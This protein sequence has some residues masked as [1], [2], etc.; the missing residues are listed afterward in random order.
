MRRREIVTGHGKRPR[1]RRFTKPFTDLSR[2]ADGV[3]QHWAI[4]N[5]Q[6]WVLD[7]QFGEDANRTRVDHSA[8]N[9]ALMR[10]MALTAFSTLT[11]FVGANLFAPTLLLMSL[12][13]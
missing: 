12:L 13:T 4:E 5:S 10:R 11:R 1:P 7:V 2:F 3:R 9:L 8:E 6:H